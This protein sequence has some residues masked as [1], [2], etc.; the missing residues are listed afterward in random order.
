MNTFFPIGSTIE[1]SS[2]TFVE[3]RHDN[4]LIV[5]SEFNYSV[6]YSVDDGDGAWNADKKNL[7]DTLLYFV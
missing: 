6:D 1:N 5:E 4:S 3:K 7:A 2:D